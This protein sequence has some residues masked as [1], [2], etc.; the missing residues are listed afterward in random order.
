[1]Q[2]G[3]FILCDMHICFENH[4]KINSSE[5]PYDLAEIRNDEQKIVDPV[6]DL[7]SFPPKT[8]NSGNKGSFYFGGK[9]PNLITAAT[10][11]LLQYTFAFLLSKLCA[12]VHK[13]NQ[14]SPFCEPDLII[15]RH[16]TSKS[17]EFDRIS[18]VAAKASCVNTFIFSVY[19]QIR[20]QNEPHT[21]LPLT[22]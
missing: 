22:C 4:L 9:N 5:E 17:L 12:P 2:L 7:S 6:P 11:F 14:F 1:M 18:T 21:L 3:S 13:V 19:S 10:I 16:I 20:Q 8:R 15:S